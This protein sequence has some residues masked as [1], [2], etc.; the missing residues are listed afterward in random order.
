MTGRLGFLKV[1]LEPAFLGTFLD[2]SDLFV[3]ELEFFAEICVKL[4]KTFEK[5][6]NKIQILVVSGF[7]VGMNKK[8]PEVGTRRASRQ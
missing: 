2:L 6:R 3:A 4:S 1:V 8:D 7:V 5:S